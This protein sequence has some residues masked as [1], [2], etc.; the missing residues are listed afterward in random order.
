M[1]PPGF[2]ATEMGEP[3]LL[4]VRQHGPRPPAPK[5]GAFHEP[6][7]ADAPRASTTLKPAE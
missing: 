6:A 1:I 5:A 7:R 3:R 2:A 4:T